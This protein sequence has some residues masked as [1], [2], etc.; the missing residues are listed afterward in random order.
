MNS[1]ELVDIASKETVRLLIEIRKTSGGIPTM[2][3][4]K[5]NALIRE[6]EELGRIL[7]TQEEEHR[8]LLLKLKKER[9]ERAAKKL[10]SLS[11][12][13]MLAKADRKV[14]RTARAMHKCGE[15][16]AKREEAR[17]QHIMATEKREILRQAIREQF[18]AS[19]TANN[20][21]TREEAEAQR[22]AYLKSQKE[23]MDKKYAEIIAK[24]KLKTQ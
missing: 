2:H 21:P 1:G 10:I 17:E 3:Y 24:R 14:T 18:D 6:N 7:A 5:A 23:Q 22:T 15:G 11:P 13:E 19:A 12:W 16:T 9:E 8:E 4:R 20:E